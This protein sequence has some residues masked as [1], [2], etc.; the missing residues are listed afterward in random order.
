MVASHNT[1]S[2]MHAQWWAEL[3]SCFWRCQSHSASYQHGVLNV[4][5]C[6]IRVR[7]DNGKWQLCHGIARFGDR[8]SSLNDLVDWCMGWRFSSFRIICENG[9]YD[10]FEK[11]VYGLSDNNMDRCLCAIYNPD[12]KRVFDSGVQIIEHNKHMWYEDWHLLKNIMNFLYPSIKR[13]ARENNKLITDGNVHMYD[14]V[15]FIK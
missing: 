15:E 3:V 4:S 14:Y 5:V 12:W 6:D 1:F 10:D 13:Y 8:Y 2:Y 7:L 9:S 11:A